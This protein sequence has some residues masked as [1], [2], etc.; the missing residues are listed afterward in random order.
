M[1]NDLNNQVIRLENIMIVKDE[2]IDQLSSS[3]SN[4][5]TNS[6]MNSTSTSTST[7]S[8]VKNNVDKSKLGTAFNSNTTSSKSNPTKPTLSS[9]SQA[10]VNS[11]KT[12]VNS[13][14]K[15]PNVVQ[16]KDNSNLKS[17]SNPNP[18]AK[19]LNLESVRDK[20]KE[21]YLSPSLSSGA[22]RK[23]SFLS[24]DESSNRGKQL[25]QS[26]TMDRNKNYIKQIKDRKPFDGLHSS[27]LSS[28]NANQMGG[29]VD[30]TKKIRNRET[31]GNDI[32]HFENV[33]IDSLEFDHGQIHLSLEKK[34]WIGDKLKLQKP[35]QKNI[36][37]SPTPVNNFKK[38]IGHSI[39]D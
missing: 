12:P 37:K 14:K 13:M 22:K 8:L 10:K 3:L 19:H 38:N 25:S 2:K 33:L 11:P 36:S 24:D 17:N 6:N 30:A 21:T 23:N 32:D 15:K 28:S 4:S 34:D 1:V 9:K 26:V 18:T 27:S 5:N 20:L 31:G 16:G 35:N 39:G 7:S 29:S